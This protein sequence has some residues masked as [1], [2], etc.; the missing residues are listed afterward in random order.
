MEW[1]LKKSESLQL[2]TQLNRGLCWVL[3]APKHTTMFLF[4][5]IRR[6]ELAAGSEGDATPQ[7]SSREIRA[8]NDPFEVDSG[9]DS[10]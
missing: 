1:K 10:F 8:E 6:S 9:L 4:Q 3:V 5:A 2:D 7:R